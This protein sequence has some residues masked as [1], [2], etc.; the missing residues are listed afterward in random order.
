MNHFGKSAAAGLLALTLSLGSGLTAAFATEELEPVLTEEVS[1]EDV[2]DETITEVPV[3]EPAP[4]IEDVVEDDIL[5]EVLP[6]VIPEVPIVDDVIVEQAGPAPV[7]TLPEDE[8]NNSPPVENGQPDPTNSEEYWEQLLGQECYKFEAGESSPYGALTDDG[9][10]VILNENNYPLVTLIVKGGSVDNGDGPGNVVYYGAEAGVVYDAPL[11]NGGQQAGVSHWIVCF[12]PPSTYLELPEISATYD[13][14]DRE[15][16]VSIYGSY[17]DEYDVP[18]WKYGV[19]SYVIID[20]IVVLGFTTDPGYLFPPPGEDDTYYFVDGES[21]ELGANIE[22]VFD[23]TPQVEACDGEEEE[24]T[25]P[26]GDI[27]TD[28]ADPVIG[29]A[30]AIV[31]GSVPEGASSSSEFIVKVNETQALAPYVIEPGGEFQITMNFSEDTGQ[32]LVEL[33]VGDEV[34][35]SVAVDTDCAE[36][37]EPGSPSYSFVEKCTPEGKVGEFDFI[38]P[39]NEFVFYELAVKGVDEPYEIVVGPG[40]GSMKVPFLLTEEGPGPDF[41]LSQDGEV[42]A[43]YFVEDCEVEEEPEEPTEPEVPVTPEIP[44]TPNNPVTPTQPKAPVTT[45]PKVLATTGADPSGLLTLATLVLIGGTSLI[46]W[47]RRLAA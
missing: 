11:N 4:P 27:V 5:V 14:I 1:T 32:Y 29:G 24:P 30:Y 17:Y 39:T 35:A 38:N 42:L 21:G 45:A 6:E 20:H 26:V 44:T 3:E 46:V 16:S 47:R 13:C 10:G 22:I 40:T 37:E 7:D 2:V 19:Y 43:E 36:N 12:S 33:F 15:V 28:C 31:S 8:N 23:L 9:N 25:V 18:R 34:L 41:V